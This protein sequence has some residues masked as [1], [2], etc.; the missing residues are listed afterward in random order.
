MP[1]TLPDLDTKS[2]QDIVDEMIASIPNYT[3]KWTNYNVS[4]PG[5]TILEMV[6][7]IT[8]ATLYRINKIPDASYVNFLRLLAGVSGIDDIDRLLADPN[9]FRSHRDILEFLLEI[10]TGNETNIIDMKAAALTFLNSR[11]RAVTKEDFRELAIEATDSDL[12]Y[13]GDL[14][15]TVRLLVK[16]SDAKDHVSLFIYESFSSTMKGLL[17]RFDRSAPLSPLLQQTLIDELN[18]LIQSGYINKEESFSEVKLSD[19]T[20]VL[21]QKQELHGEAHILLNRMLLEDAYPDQLENIAN[22]AKVIRAIVDQSTKGEKVRIIIVSN[23]RDKYKAL[24]EQVKEYLDPRRLI[25]T[26]IEVS[27]PVYTGVGIHV[28]IELTSYEKV[29]IVQENVRTRIL[30]YLDPLTGGSKGSGW[31]YGRPLIIYEVVQVV[32]DTNGV[33][34]TVSVVIDNDDDL[35]KKTIDGLIDVSVEVEVV[36]EVAGDEF[37]K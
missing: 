37:Q 22:R 11:Y 18:R 14:K 7:W 36:E 9:L 17:E 3:D 13:T 26:V 6:C 30:N 21:M 20:K 12:F 10:E 31:P 4:D 29:E 35:K 24:I 27:S 16:L 15:D 33:K 28:K 32:E 1:I 25:G 23:R 8:E 2:Y 19:R 5:I 34:R